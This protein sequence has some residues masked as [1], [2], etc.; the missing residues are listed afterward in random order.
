MRQRPGL[1]FTLI[2]LLVVISIIA[3]LIA[4]LL[5]ALGAA[6][7][8]GR[9]VQCSSLLKQFGIANAVYQ[10]DH[11]E[12]NLPGE[13]TEDG[14]TPP[15]MTWYSVPSFRESLGLPRT[16]NWG[17]P[18][19]SV[20]RRIFN[21]GDHGELNCPSKAIEDSTFPNRIDRSFGVNYEGY[22]GDAG[23][24]APNPGNGRNHGAPDGNNYLKSHRAFELV[25]PS[26][27]YFF[28][29]ANAANVNRTNADAGTWE[30]LGESTTTLA[31][32]IYRHQGAANVSLYDGHVE[33][34]QPD[35]LQDAAI[36]P[37]WR[38]AYQ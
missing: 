4:I 32:P 36:D 9:A 8:A 15:T 1:G 19:F 18:G 28:I 2:E 37:S 34:R 7:D 22:V 17:A 6:R 35:A 33:R 26:A 23:G 21:F 11:R 30:A 24:Y 5:P 31:R 25:N 10:N 20:F 13:Y 29:D 16:D 14:F 12:W 27:A 3:L 38:Y